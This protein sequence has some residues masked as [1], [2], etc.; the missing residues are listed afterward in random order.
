MLT[1]RPDG[2]ILT[3]VSLDP[4]FLAF[5]YCGN[6]RSP[7]AS[8]RGSSR[9]LAVVLVLLAIVVTACSTAK[10]IQYPKDHERI[11]RIDK[12]VESLR[13]AYQKKNYSNFQS[14][15]LPLNQLGGLQHQV[16]EDFETFHAISLEFTIERIMIEGDDVA[17]NIHWQGLWKKTAEDV[18]V[19]QR[20]HARFQWAGTH[21]IL[22]RAVQGDLP[23]GMKAKQALSEGSPAQ[24]RL[25]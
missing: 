10:E 22:L 8:V 12:A 20:G 9:S 16:E 13:D 5:L 17:V 21:S 23:F 14:M 7:W 19:R 18:G 6:M 4:V 25:R 24:P 1:R 3:K 15:L 2:C 11:R